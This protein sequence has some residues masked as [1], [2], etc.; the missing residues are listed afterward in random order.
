M[1]FSLFFIGLLVCLLNGMLLGYNHGFDA[2]LIS[3]IGI[4]GGSLVTYSVQ[5]GNKN[6]N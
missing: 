3:N 1:K 4:I 5:N 2:V 6:K